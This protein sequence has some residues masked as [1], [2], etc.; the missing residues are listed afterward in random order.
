MQIF[1]QTCR[2]MFLNGCTRLCNLI[3][4]IVDILGSSRAKRSPLLQDPKG[5]HSSL[6]ATA[7]P[8]KIDM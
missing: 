1:V 3:W 4:F 5:N 6:A 8:A 2:H 7:P